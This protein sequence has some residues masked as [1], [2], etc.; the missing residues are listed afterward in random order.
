[1]F[2]Q[3]EEL[4]RYLQ[5]GYNQDKLPIM[6]IQNLKSKEIDLFPTWNKMFMLLFCTKISFS[7]SQIHQNWVTHVNE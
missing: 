6:T 2:F 7:G 4:I 3:K 5:R 1:M